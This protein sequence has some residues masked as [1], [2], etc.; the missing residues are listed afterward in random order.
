MLTQP[1]RD[2]VKIFGK[3]HITGTFEVQ[4]AIEVWGAVTIDGYMFVHPFSNFLNSP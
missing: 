3:L 4:S 1:C 2:K